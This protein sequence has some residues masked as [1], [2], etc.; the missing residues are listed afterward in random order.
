MSKETKK[1]TAKSVITGGIEKGKSVKFI[2]SQLSKKLPDSKAD[3]SHVRFYAN[4]MVADGT[5]KT[6]VAE[7]KYGCGKRGRKSAD[8]KKPIGKKEKVST[9][10]VSTKKVDKKPAVKK[11]AASKKSESVKSKKTTSTRKTT[12]KK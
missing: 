1:V 4:K 12:S 11:S 2:L 9:K 3:A 10:K 6:D 8:T 7:E 5:L